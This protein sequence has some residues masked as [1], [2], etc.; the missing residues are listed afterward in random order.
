MMGPP[1]SSNP[2]VTYVMLDRPATLLTVDLRVG[3]PKPE[4]H[5]FCARVG[6]GRAC[7]DRLQAL[8]ELQSDEVRRGQ[9]RARGSRY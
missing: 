9:Q 8:I 4:P 1:L 6:G 3:M 7:I 2:S 5:D